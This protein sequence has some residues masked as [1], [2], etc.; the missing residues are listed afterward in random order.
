MSRYSEDKVTK[1]LA[2]F[3]KDMNK[4]FG[5]N[6]FDMECSGCKKLVDDCRKALLQDGEGK[7]G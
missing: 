5:I 3:G 1:I 7:S 2:Q 4:H 6:D